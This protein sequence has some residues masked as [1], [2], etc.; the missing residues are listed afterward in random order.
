MAL[1]GGLAAAAAYYGRRGVPSFALCLEALIFLVGFSTIFSVLVYGAGVG[2][3]PLADSWLKSCD[4]NLGI[5]AGDIVLWVN[6][7]PWLAGLFK[8]AYFSAIPQTILAIVMLGFSNDAITLRRLLLRF[9]LCGLATL[10]GFYFLPAIG[11][12][13]SYPVAVPDFYEGIVRDLT[14]L[15]EGSMRH[16]SWNAAEGLITFPS[17]HCEWSV[18]LALAFAKTR[19]WPVM[20]ILNL[21]MAVSSVPVGM[22]YAT[23]AI[24]GLAVCLLVIPV[25]NYLVRQTSAASTQRSGA[26]LL[27]CPAVPWRYVKADPKIEA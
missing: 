4:S 2:G 17:F 26:P 18:L 24:G 8:V 11:T 3:R 21:L 15:R 22:H 12:M 14:A 23:D 9:M 13:A 16:V 1:C 7:Y 20:L 27:A 10:A 19:I 6:S 5:S 25:S